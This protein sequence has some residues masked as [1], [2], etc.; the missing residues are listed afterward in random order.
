MI[1][2]SDGSNVLEAKID[3]VTRDHWYCPMKTNAFE[4][5]WL[6]L[7]SLVPPKIHCWV[8]NIKLVYNSKTNAYENAPGVE[9]RVPYWGEVE[10]LNLDPSI[11]FQKSNV[12]KEFIKTMEKFVVLNKSLRVAPY[13][14]RFIPSGPYYLKLR[15]LV[16]ET[17]KWNGENPVVLI[18]HSMGCKV[19]LSFL[20][21][22][23]KA[24]KQKYIRS[25]IPI[26]GVFGGSLDE[27]KLFA[28]GSNEGIPFVNALTIREEQR[29]YESNYWMFPLPDAFG[30]RI[31]AQT[32]SRN[33]SASHYSDFFKDI[34]LKSGIRQYEGAR[35]RT[36]MKFPGVRTHHIFGDGVATPM[37]F[38]WGNDTFQSPPTEVSFSAKGDGTVQLCSLQYANKMW[39]K[40][41]LYSHR[42]Y[43]GCSHTGILEDDGVL[44]D[45]I[46]MIGL[47]PEY[48]ALS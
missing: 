19:T 28:S 22:M 48:T 34:D 13:D 15:L 2:C 37:K 6:D 16:E 33:Y 11:P 36:V 24:W 30:Q 42:K 25:W 47:T 8:E 14:F 43:R 41:V 9:T 26:A 10:S 7:S 31:I 32:S 35:N 12:W 29:S 23:S 38:A 5:L 39:S 44:S 45:L 27:I 17:F 40:N 1:T 3:K 46:Q 21:A 4:R 20:Q 18:S